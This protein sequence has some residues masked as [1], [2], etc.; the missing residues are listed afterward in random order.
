MRENLSEKMFFIATYVYY[1]YQ[2][3]RRV[4]Y[5]VKCQYYAVSE[6]YLFNSAKRMYIEEYL[7]GG[8]NSYFQF[9]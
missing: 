2:I 9:A 3:T 8:M 1:T 5:W 4:I 6:A 7:M